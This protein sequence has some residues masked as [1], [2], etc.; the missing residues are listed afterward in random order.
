M[1]NYGTYFILIGRLR[2]CQTCCF[3]MTWGAAGLRGADVA[4]YVSYV[5]WHLP[6]GDQ[7]FAFTF[8]Y[9]AVAGYVFVYEAECQVYGLGFCVC[10]V[11]HCVSQV[12]HVP[13]GAHVIENAAAAM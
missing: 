1:V 2:Q 7:V 9:M 6:A 12:L 3:F 11:G 13:G 5:V 4:A 10:C 8:I